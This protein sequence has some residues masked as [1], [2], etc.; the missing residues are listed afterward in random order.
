[1][2]SQSPPASN[3]PPATAAAAASSSSSSSSSSASSFLHSVSGNISAAW[4]H[5][6][7]H[8]ETHLQ[9]LGVVSHF[10]PAFPA[11]PPG[12]APPA[13]AP[14]VSPLSPAAAAAA[15][16][17]RPAASLGPLLRFG[18]I[19]AGGTL[20]TG[21]VLSIAPHGAPPP[22]LTLFDVAAGGAPSGH[23]VPATL[24][25]TYA[26]W[27]FYRFDL[28]LRLD[29][30]ARP[31]EYSVAGS[32]GGGG[33]QHPP[34]RYRFFVPAA[35]EDSHVAFWS[36]N[37]FGSDAKDVDKKW[38]GI[39][40]LWRD[41]L[42]RHAEAPFHVQ[43]GG[44]DQVYS[45]GKHNIFDI[46][47]VAAWLGTDD[48][49]DRPKVQWTAEH[50]KSIGDFY[51]LTYVH[52]FQEEEFAEALA[53][54]PY[55]FL[56]DDHDIMDGYGSYPE[57]IMNSPVMKNVGRLAYRFYLLFQQHTT[58]AEA[59]GLFPAPAGFSYIKSLGPSTAV[60]AIDNR[61]G[62]TE[63]RVVPDICWMEI[64]KQLEIAAVE[65]R[66]K[67]KH[68]L[69]IA[70]VP[71]VY[72][73]MKIADSVIN[74]VASLSEM[75]RDMF[76]KVVPHNSSTAEVREGVLEGVGHSP[77]MHRILG[78]FGQPDLRDDLIDEWTHEY[79]LA[80]R[81]KMVTEFQSFSKKHNVRIT[82][83]SGDV[84]L[85]AIGRFRSTGDIPDENGKEVEHDHRAMYQLVSSAIGNNPP[86]SMIVQ[87]LHTNP[88]ILD[89]KTTGIT[90]TV[91]EMFETFKS[92][93]NGKSL[94]E[95][96][97]LPRR[98]WSSISYSTAD[99]SL[100]L[101]LH[102]EDV[103]KKDRDAVLYKRRVPSLKPMP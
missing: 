24:L 20:W 41:L 21:S 72:P 62:R 89:S 29:A 9:Q 50:E 6:K 94:K 42:R 28:T 100:E 22:T 78:S 4:S 55:T 102:V 32:A 74:S 83:I 31:V 35:D 87:Y 33:A 52:H 57:A 34:R 13:T 69:V 70:T 37:G 54:I 30:R 64:W 40:P 7:H 44:G 65:S 43:I 88:R 3:N 96:R 15:P 45:D 16:P 23:S 82:F 86:P 79:H 25:D 39:Q 68:L 93:V 63:H 97:L 17:L 49:A 98:N 27:C 26:A 95:S 75:F 36:C 80:E 8:A 71:V 38:N 73:R 56:C 1:M 19:A 61:S 53:T 58:F 48:I 5:V 84:H 59:R 90:D 2:T 66:G 12:L 10:P 101:V 103:D 99:R 67:L 77:F 14:A 46:P 91:E 92:D 85:C 76:R 60:L 11:P 47:L 81:N 51:F 18:G